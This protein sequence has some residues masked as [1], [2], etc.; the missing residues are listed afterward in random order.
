MT[1]PAKLLIVLCFVHV[2]A[3]RVP[4]QDDED[5]QSWNE[6]QVS[7]P[8]AERVDLLLLSTARVGRN[9][10]SLVEGRIGAGLN[11]H[12]TRAMS[13]SPTYQHIET[14]DSAGRFRTEHRVSLR[15]TFKFP[16]KGF[17]LSHRSIIE[18]RYRAAGNSWR[19]RP[20]VTFEKE[21]PRHLL[22][23]AK[24]FLTEEPFYVSTTK[25]F[26]RNRFSVGV[27]KQINKHLTLDVYYLRQ[28]DGFSHPGDLNVIGTSWKVVL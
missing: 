6:L 23:Q 24:L 27:S 12:L 13:F 9:I 20:S 8:L 22:G 17:G 26:A 16:T 11:F 4:G 3:A 19:Y 28:S 10:R 21:L 25:R 1:F 18:L 2:A 15:G 7:I 14:R 5:T